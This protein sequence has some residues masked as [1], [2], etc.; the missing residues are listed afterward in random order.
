MPLPKDIKDMLVKTA[1]RG[2][3]CTYDELVD[4]FQPDSRRDLYSAL[5]KINTETYDAEGYLLSSVVIGEDGLPGPGFFRKL[6]NGDWRPKDAV[7]ANAPARDIFRDE[8]VKA[9]DCWRAPRKILPFIDLE[10][11]AAGKKIR[12]GVI[13]ALN[14]MAKIRDKGGKNAYDLLPH[15]GFMHARTGSKWPGQCV[16]CSVKKSAGAASCNH[17]LNCLNQAG[18]GM[19]KYQTHPDAAGRTNA[20][21]NYLIGEWFSWVVK[22]AP[23]SSRRVLTRRDIV[24]IFADD[25]GYHE[26]V[27]RAVDKGFKVWGFGNGEMV[28]DKNRGREDSE[29]K[30]KSRLQK[31]RKAFGENFYD[32]RHDP[33]T[34]NFAP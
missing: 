4:K 18:R 28:G 19:K 6:R 20:A 31:F 14:A 8:L 27:L 13:H 22:G 23:I 10:N 9:Y 32:L 11:M 34:W 3:L 33:H 1:Q 21:D 7:V 25:A 30:A 24:C 15:C 16:N 17:C 26:S 12:A 29:E 5:D 2:S